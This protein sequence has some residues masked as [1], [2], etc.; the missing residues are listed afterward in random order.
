M[1]VCHS[2]SKLIMVTLFL[3]GRLREMACVALSDRDGAHELRVSELDL[4][5]VLDE[6]LLGGSESRANA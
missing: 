3:A 5:T 6:G 1:T 2:D 4:T